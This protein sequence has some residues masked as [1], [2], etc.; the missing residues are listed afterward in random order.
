MKPGRVV[1]VG[2][3][4][5]GG[6]CAYYLAKAGWAVEL[7]DRG[8]FGAACSHGNCGYVCPS[9]VF[10]LAKPGA[11]ASTLPLMLRRNSPFMVRP[12]LDLHMLAWFARFAS[13]CREDLVRETSVALN[14]LLWSSKRC[15][16]SI[17]AEEGID[18]DWT[19]G[20]CLFISMDEEHLEHF[21]PINA[22]IR[23]R[24]GFGA[25][26]WDGRMLTSREPT[27]RDG[28]AGAWYFACDAHVRADKFMRG[29]GSALRRLGVTIHEG[30]EATGL[31]GE[32]GRG[33]TL[34]TTTGPI[35][36]DAFVFATGAWTPLL[37]R[38][39]GTRLPIQPG[40]GYSFTTRRPR[41][42]PTYPMIFEQHRVAVTPFREGFRVGS[43]MEF[44]GY[45]ESIRPER[46]A[47]LRDS[48]K[49]YFRE[50]TDEPM[51][52]TWFGWRP[53][54]PDGRPFIGFTEH[55]GNVLVAAGHNMIGMSTGP[56]TGRLVAELLSDD[57]PHINPAPFRLDR[58][59]L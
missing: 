43:T 25:E 36:A 15:Y 20:G 55:R 22:E 50:W 28:L 8:G 29:L 49:L 6:S 35:S 56:G 4:V 10:P 47:L 30:R 38:S 54:T 52:E 7:V 48:A 59:C 37:A 53:M 2:G 58:P 14:E 11:I 45:D 31:V 57:E 19:D 9:H 32:N 27:L 18:C 39:L 42:C 44:A 46:L 17:I 1:V 23:A 24:F 3:G 51:E 13:C 34:E 40:K 16:E 12:R 26:R 21:E 33:R 5:V 41:A